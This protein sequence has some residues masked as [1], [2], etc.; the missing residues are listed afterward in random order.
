[1]RVSVFGLGYVGAVTCACLARDGHEVIGVDL[2]AAKVSAIGSG[3]SPIIEPQ[4]EELLAAA[5]TSGALRATCDAELAVLQ[6][7]VS[8]VSVGTPPAS[9]GLA[10]LT[11]VERVTQQIADAT[12]RK[13]SEH[14]FVLRST[15]PPGTT[16][17]CRQMFQ[18][19]GQDHV[20]VAFNPEFLREGSAVF[21]YDNPAYTIVGTEDQAAAESLHLLYASVDA[22]FIVVRP[23]EAEMV[24]AVANAWHA[25]KISFANEIGRL[26]ADL[27]VD[28]RAV[29]DLICQDTKLNISK[30]YMR[31]GFAFGGS[32]LPKDVASLVAT[33]RFSNTEVPLLA[34]LARS[35]ATTI[36]RA[37]SM[38]LRDGPRKVAVLG[39]A[40]KPGTDDLRESPAVALVKHLIAEGCEVSIFDADVEK[41]RLVGSNLEFIRTHL[42]HFETMLRPSIAAT[43]QD[44]QVVVLTYRSAEFD[45]PV[46]ELDN[47][48][49][50]VDL[51]GAVEHVRDGVDY[52]GIA[53]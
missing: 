29:M 39:L 11:F 12:A 7:D 10:D 16:R 43:L 15:V 17:R 19:A 23:E 28:G 4:L 36:E 25:T 3:R 40:F 9:N 14:A 42:P 34:S 22:P 53:W 24:K 50:L 46:S 2:D 51:A 31:P 6:S 18:D 44:A 20:Q 45:G 5:S 30:V 49:R 26:S 27:G 32:C 1:M 33:A 47:D 13:T 37:A 52:M 35:N 48:V 38:V 41:A 8:F 21:D